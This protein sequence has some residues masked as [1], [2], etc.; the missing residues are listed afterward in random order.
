MS[1]FRKIWI[2]QCAAAEGIRERFGVNDALRY[3]PPLD[4]IGGLH[5]KACLEARPDPV[6]LARRWKILQKRWSFGVFDR[7]PTA[8]EEVLGAE[9]LNEWQRGENGPR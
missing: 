5:R 9:G 4:G 3:L 6:Q 7:F 1:E 2:D 8:Y